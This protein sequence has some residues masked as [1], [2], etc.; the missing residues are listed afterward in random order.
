MINGDLWKQL[1]RYWLSR[2]VYARPPRRSE[3]D[4]PVEVP[5]LA[6]NLMLIEVIDD[7]FRYRLT[8]SALYERY[9]TGLTGTW[10]QQRVEAETDWHATLAAVRDDQIPRL[11]STPVP[12]QASV[13]H[14]A[15]AL[16]LLDDEDKVHQ[17][18]A[19]AFFAQEFGGNNHSGRLEIRELFRDAQ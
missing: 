17:I 2:R 9:Q 13:F 3:L 16:P 11:L 19:G 18:L 12:G 6:A 7:R 10:I 5:H 1:Y 15:V 8:G 14:A 4:I